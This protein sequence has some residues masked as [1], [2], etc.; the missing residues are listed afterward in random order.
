MDENGT[1]SV[2]I[3]EA[4]SSVT[5]KEACRD[6]EPV[7]RTLLTTETD[8]QGSYRNRVRTRRKIARWMKDPA[9]TPDEIFYMLDPF[10]QSIQGSPPSAGFIPQSALAIVTLEHLA[11]PQQQQANESSRNPKVIEGNWEYILWMCTKYLETTSR[12]WC[13]YPL[14]Y[15]VSAS[16]NWL[17]D[18]L[19]CPNPYLRLEMLRLILLFEFEFEYGDSQWSYVLE[20]FISTMCD[21][22]VDHLESKGLELVFNSC[23]LIE[24]FDILQTKKLLPCIGEKIMS[25]LNANELGREVL[26]LVN[27]FKLLGKL[28]LMELKVVKTQNFINNKLKD[29]EPMEAIKYPLN[30]L[31]ST[32]KFFLEFLGLLFEGGTATLSTACQHPLVAPS[33][34][35]A[36]ADISEAVINLE[37][38]ICSFKFDPVITQK[39]LQL[40]M[41]ELREKLVKYFCVQIK[42]KPLHL[43]LLQREHGGYKKNFMHSFNRSLF[44]VKNLQP[45]NF[46]CPMQY[47]TPND[48]SDMSEYEE[49]THLINAE[50]NPHE[51]ISEISHN[52]ERG[53]TD[54]DINRLYEDLVDLVDEE[55]D[56]TRPD[57]ES[58]E[59]GVSSTEAVESDSDVSSITHNEDDMS[60]TD[61][62]S[63]Y[64]TDES[65]NNNEE[66]NIQLPTEE[67]PQ[68]A[69]REI[70]YD[71]T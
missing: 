53:N 6:L 20:G 50:Y 68:Y 24:L 21:I 56:A 59:D 58:M 9:R 48:R 38:L 8:I 54:D 17:C 47:P 60:S 2:T 19:L 11:Q 42:E 23:D 10:F 25:Q 34:S 26:F 31:K 22:N 16:L 5:L 27:V 18:P 61:D 63:L 64:S 69:S 30:C 33:V 57:T 41:M 1:S 3:N 70:I 67:G 29:M 65:D 12:L 55:F 43:K 35:T 39:L 32:F 52:S 66:E 40:P 4:K 28:V 44:S 49:L 46:I 13:P 51:Y 37:S 62:S 15:F 45:T 7:L 71:N 14:K 36:I